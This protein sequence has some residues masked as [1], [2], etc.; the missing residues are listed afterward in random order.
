M[1]AADPREVLG[2]ALESAASRGLSLRPETAVLNDA[3][4]DFRV[5][6]VEDTEGADWILRLP[7]RSRSADRIARE[8]AVRAAGLAP[9]PG[10]RRAG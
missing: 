8:A 9:P 1:T 5:V 4:W 10:G 2:A 7:R 3:G 6:E